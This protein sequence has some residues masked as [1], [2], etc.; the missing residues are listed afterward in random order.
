MF[1]VTKMQ[2]LNC[3][4]GM[5]VEYKAAHS[6][7][8][9][10]YAHKNTMSAETGLSEWGL[11]CAAGFHSQEEQWQVTKHGNMDSYCIS[12]KQWEVCWEVKVTVFLSPLSHLS[13]QTAK[14]EK[15]I[16]M[17]VIVTKN[18]EG[19]GNLKHILFI[20]FLFYQRLTHLT[21]PEWHLQKVSCSQS[22]RENANQ[23]HGVLWWQK[24]RKEQELN[25]RVKQL[26]KLLR[27]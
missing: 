24:L 18:A 12:E 15:K 20:C 13:T 22:N 27:K 19:N 5:K 17:A 2:S 8:T 14:N 6:S 7:R 1:G 21:L 11:L 10:Q 3:I 25:A 4:M 9:Q 26:E 23:V 16:K